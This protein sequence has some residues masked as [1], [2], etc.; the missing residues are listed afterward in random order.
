M[1][2]GG[3]GC[4]EISTRSL[5]S[6]QA[7]RLRAAWRI[8]EL[9]RVAE[10][11]PER[12]VRQWAGHPRGRTTWPTRSVSRSA[13]PGPFSVCERQ[14][15]QTHRRRTARRP[16]RIANIRHR[17]RTDE[18]HSL[19]SARSSQRRVFRAAAAV[20]RDRSGSRSVC[21]RAVLLRG[22]CARTFPLV[23]TRPVP[24]AV[25]ACT[26]LCG[27]LPGRDRDRIP[28]FLGQFIRKPVRPSTNLRNAADGE[29][30]AAQS[31]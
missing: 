21:G 17:L 28:D 16:A 18:S 11:L 31:R 27:V 19:C 2:R 5:L 20:G 3:L 6:I 9:P 7:R 15:S 12:G 30:I 24:E 14:R 23:G 10:S 13:A 29:P 8:A 25:A 22:S 1:P 4:I 26:L